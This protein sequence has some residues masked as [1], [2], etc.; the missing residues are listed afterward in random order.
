[1]MVLPSLLLAQ[2]KGDM[3][4]FQ[5]PNG[6]FAGMFKSSTKTVTKPAKDWSYLS[7][8]GVALKRVI[9]QFKNRVEYSSV[10]EELN[11]GY[12]TDAYTAY[13]AIQQAKVDLL[14]ITIALY[15]SDNAQADTYQTVENAVALQVAL[16]QKEIK[17]RA[18]TKEKNDLLNYLNKEVNFKQKI[19]NYSNTQVNFWKGVIWGN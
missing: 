9:D 19:T 10:V 15:E 18:M 2:S 6:A 5:G 13:M 3:L 8:E 11:Q 16:Q 12:L 14:D 17:V 7:E 1:M 4:P